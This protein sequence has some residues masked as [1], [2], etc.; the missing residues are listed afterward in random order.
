M[1]VSR[2]CWHS[3]G[4]SSSSFFSGRIHFVNHRE[5]LSSIN[6]LNRLRL[7]MNDGDD[8]EVIWLNRINIRSKIDGEKCSSRDL[9]RS[10]MIEFG[11]LTSN[12]NRKVCREMNSVRPSLIDSELMFEKG[13]MTVQKTLV[14]QFTISLSKKASFGSPAA[15]LEMLIQCFARSTTQTLSLN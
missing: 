7:L 1:N 10:V 2:I 8:D 13:S 4:E 5:S 3:S 14:I 9:I 12:N 11:R 6:A 15:V